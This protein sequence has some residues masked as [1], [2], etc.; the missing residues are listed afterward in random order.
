MILKQY[1]LTVFFPLVAGLFFTT[2][3]CVAGTVKADLKI[4]VL[5]SQAAAPFDETIQGFKEYLQKAGTA[6][7]YLMLTLDGESRKTTNAIEEM[8]QFQ[9]HLILALGSIAAQ[10]AA[11]NISDVPIIAGMILSSDHTVK[12]KNVSGVFLDY[13]LETQF[14]FFRLVLPQAKTI[15]VIYNVQENQEKI[16]RVEALGRE[17]G[18]IIFKQ[19]VQ[20]P[21]EIPAALENIAKIADAL[22]A[23][24]DNI[25]YTPQTVKNILLF[26]YRNRIP[27]IGLSSTWVKAGAVY[28]LDWDY[29]DVGETCGQKALTIVRGEK[30]DTEAQIPVKRVHYAI[31]Q[32]AAE[33]MK[34]EIPEKVLRDATQVY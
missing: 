15:A 10:T 31:N 23:I 30:T 21:R 27:F 13:P 26:S 33:H 14:E 28:A 4:A 17:M 5:A 34:V 22:L 25:V 8:R 19:P 6:P 2:S 11:D 3:V 16:N 32:K 24:P 12:K 20:T 29:T 7:D 1:I 9:P 18:L